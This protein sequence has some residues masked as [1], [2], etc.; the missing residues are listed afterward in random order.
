MNN[1]AHLNNVALVSTLATVLQTLHDIE[2]RKL[3]LDHYAMK[4]VVVNANA[5]TNL[6]EERGLTREFIDAVPPTLLG[7][8][9][10]RGFK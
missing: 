6:V 5:L 1:F 8:L 4:R 3:K 9:K 7:K 2:T 10:K